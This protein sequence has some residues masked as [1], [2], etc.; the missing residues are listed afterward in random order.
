MAGLFECL[1]LFTVV[2][3]LA[4]TCFDRQ[5]CHMMKDSIKVTASQAITEKLIL[6]HNM[7]Q[8]SCNFYIPITHRYLLSNSIAVD[9]L[10]YTLCSFKCRKPSQIE[11]FV[12]VSCH[13]S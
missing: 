4:V 8:H 13:F 7:V 11:L 1:P 10:E 2:C 6:F 3:M 9:V 12:L 5:I